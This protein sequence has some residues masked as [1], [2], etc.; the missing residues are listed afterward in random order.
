MQGLGYASLWRCGSGW[1][2]S[3]RVA[4]SFAADLKPLK[5]K[6]PAS[7]IKLKLWRD[8]DLRIS[9]FHAGIQ[10]ISPCIQE[11][12]SNV[13]DEEGSCDFRSR[14]HSVR[15]VNW[16]EFA[17]ASVRARFSLRKG[18]HQTKENSRG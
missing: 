6:E 16:R 1:M 13:R 3:K 7:E 18:R 15:D 10:P 4:S 5:G 12:K 8:P 17:R 9:D 14:E 2:L 11:H